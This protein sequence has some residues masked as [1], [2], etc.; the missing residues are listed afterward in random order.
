MLLEEINRQP[1][2]VL[3][4]VWHCLKFLTRAERKPRPRRSI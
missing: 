1:E 2:Q 3:R 4:K